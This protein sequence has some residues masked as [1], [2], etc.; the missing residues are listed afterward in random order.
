MRISTQRAAREDS[1][2]FTVVDLGVFEVFFLRNMPVCCRN[3]R[4]NTCW[5]MAP[6]RLGPEEF[7][8]ITEV[9]GQREDELMTTIEVYSRNEIEKIV[10]SYLA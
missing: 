3:W 8:D 6:S 5:V 1:N 7:D 4:S 2:K 10:L 9:L